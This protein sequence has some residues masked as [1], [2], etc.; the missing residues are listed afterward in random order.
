MIVKVVIYVK[1]K[2]RVILKTKCSKIEI[3]TATFHQ[4]GS[5]DHGKKY[6]N[7]NINI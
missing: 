1:T 6:F 3:L 4:V 7:F 2:L 5:K